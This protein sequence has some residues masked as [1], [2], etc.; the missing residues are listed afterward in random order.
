MTQEE[1]IYEHFLKSTTKSRNEAIEL[2]A[3]RD[4]TTLNRNYIHWFDKKEKVVELKS[5]SISDVIKELSKIKFEN[6][7]TEPTLSCCF[8]TDNNSQFSSDDSKIEI[9]SYIYTIV[10]FSK[11]ESL[12]KWCAKGSLWK[13]KYQPNGKDAEYC[14]KILNKAA[15]K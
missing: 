1:I 10:E 2:L 14:R 13:L 12:A 5:T 4:F 9:C 3:K 8:T 15:E 7:E 6:N 11:C